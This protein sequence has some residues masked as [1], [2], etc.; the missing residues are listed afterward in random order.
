MVKRFHKVKDREERLAMASRDKAIRLNQEK[1]E[2]LLESNPKLEIEDDAF[3]ES[4]RKAGLINI[5]NRCR[6]TP[7]KTSPYTLRDGS[8]VDYCHRCAAIS[9]KAAKKREKGGD[10]L[11]KEIQ[12]RESSN[13]VGRQEILAWGSKRGRKPKS[14]AH[15]HRENKDKKDARVQEII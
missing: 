13:T 3:T 6:S 9:Y 10:K 7:V 2:K 12:K 5:C 4:A 8:I 15:G 11:E 1:L 14:K